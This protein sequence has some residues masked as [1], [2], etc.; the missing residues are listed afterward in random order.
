MG[1]GGVGPEV[2]Q[3]QTGPVWYALTRVMEHLGDGR[4]KRLQ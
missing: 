3:Q 4:Q 1:M 2:H